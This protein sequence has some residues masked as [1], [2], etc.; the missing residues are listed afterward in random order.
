MTTIRLSGRR[1]TFIILLYLCLI[2]LPFIISRSY[3][4]ESFIQGDCYYYRAVIVSLLEDGDLLMVNNISSADPLNGQLALG[5]EVFVP[6]H[7]ILMPLVSMPF[8]LLFGDPGLLLFN[9]FDCMILVLLIFKLNC[10]FYNHLIAFITTILY[11]TGTLFLDYTYNYSPDVF[12]TV[13]LLSG[14]LL[15]L[16]GRYYV[17]AVPLGLSIFAKIPNAPLAGVILLYAGLIVLKGKPAKGSVKKH[18]QGKVTVA[19]TTALIFMVALVP[20]AY[21][22]YLLFGSPF[23]TGYQRTAVASADGQGMLVDHTSKFNQPLIQGFYRSLFNPRNGVIPT[24]PVLIM[25]FLGVFS[26]RRI[27]SHDKI[28]LILLICLIQFILFAKYDEWYTSHFSNRFM[29]TFI[30]LSSVFNSNFLSYLSHKFLLEA[31]PLQEH[32]PPT[33][34]IHEKTSK[35]GTA[36]KTNDSRESLAMQ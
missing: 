30:A 5:N 36:S 25:A 15:I 1:W 32:I 3:S 13:L 31:A 19:I 4:A 33:N 28:Y 16:H 29:M 17:G 18:F 24:N 27:R 34:V 10:L 2:Y 22:N 11:A 12:S 23:V 21:T 6:K 14:L 35:Y 7:P 26:I 20:L 8:Y 9:I